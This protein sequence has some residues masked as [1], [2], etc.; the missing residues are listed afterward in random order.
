[1]KKNDLPNISVIIPVLN[2]EENLGK[3][4]PHIFSGI[5]A[6]EELE[7]I[8]VDGGSTDQSVAVAASLGASVIKAPMG[9]ASQMNAGAR[10]A[11]A[12]V[13]YF[14][15]A[16]SFPPAGF[17]KFI[18]K[19]INDGASAGCFRLQFDSTSSFLGFFAWF[20]RFNY[21]ICRG[22]DQSLFITRELFESLG[23]F[24]ERYRVYED[25][26]FISR[27]YRQA[28]FKVLPH[29]LSTSARKYTLNGRFTLQYHFMRIHMLYYLG[30]GPEALHAY[31]QRKIKSNWQK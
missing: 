22:G 26:E 23:G 6:H 13:L 3:L 15:H 29:T 1:M 24:D 19:A 20:S 27:I 11:R 14:L 4:I 16:D 5:T 10:S 9:R 31:Y 2:E 18:L 25:N 12:K 17:A 7:I 8:I 21:P 28:K 30:K